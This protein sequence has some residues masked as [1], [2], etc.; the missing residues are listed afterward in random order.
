MLYAFGDIHGELEKL[1]ELLDATPFAAGDRLVFLPD[2]DP[3]LPDLLLYWSAGAPTGEDLPQGAHLLGAL[4]G[5]AA[6][7]LA[8]PPDPGG[9]LVAYSHRI[10]HQHHRVHQIHSRLVQRG[11]P[12]CRPW[13]SGISL[14]C[15]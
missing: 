2:R 4:D 7:T 13:W 14:D 5:D 9:H 3:S 6:R 10:G 12:R 8:P 1:E 11:H 15:C